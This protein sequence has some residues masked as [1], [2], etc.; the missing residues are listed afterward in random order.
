MKS[1]FKQYSFE[2]LTRTPRITINDQQ[3]DVNHDMQ[4]EIY[5]HKKLDNDVLFDR[6]IKNTTSFLRNNDA[7]GL[8]SMDR[9][10]GNILSPKFGVTSDI[11]V[12]TRKEG[13]ESQDRFQFKFNGNME[14]RPPSRPD[15]IRMYYKDTNNYLK[16]S[17][18]TRTNETIPI[19]VNGAQYFTNQNRLFGNV[20]STTAPPSENLS[21]RDQSFKE[22]RSPYI[23]NDKMYAYQG[24]NILSND[25]IR[26]ND[27]KIRAH[28]ER[29][30]LPQ[31][32]QHPV[33]NINDIGV[34]CRRSLPD[35]DT[36]TTS[37]FE[38]VAHS[39]PT[40]FKNTYNAKVYP[41]NNFSTSEYILKKKT[42]LNNKSTDD[43]QFK[44]VPFHD[45]RDT[46]N[47]FS[48]KTE[49]SR[50]TEIQNY[51]TDTNS[52]YVLSDLGSRPAR[53]PLSTIFPI[54]INTTITN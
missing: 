40:D 54:G 24:T 53:K 34:P 5:R 46:L 23:D 15:N 51:D 43:Y 19:D 35:D 8:N 38:H 31:P 11:G 2:D 17:V 52:T 41:S 26:Y 39:R 16:E 14:K 47:S 21:N 28:N 29:W 45:N 37:I 44:S 50:K 49:S 20:I 10:F 32:H 27:A 18:S 25:D 4:N 36:L 6:S 1:N 30:S 9:S 12:L 42:Y 48:S 22:T 3:R 13:T 33:L 7:M